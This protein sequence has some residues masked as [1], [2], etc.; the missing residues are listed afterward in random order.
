MEEKDK[1]I[2]ELL[3]EVKEIKLA[4][5]SSFKKSDTDKWLDNMDVQELL[6]ISTRTLQRLRTSGMLKYSKVN[7]KI[8][9]RLSDINT[10]LEQNQAD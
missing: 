8:Y 7:G 1:L 6:H 4:I 10:M 9:Y 5:T 3:L 2:E